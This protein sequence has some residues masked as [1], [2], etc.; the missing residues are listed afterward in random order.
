MI[1]DVPSLQVGRVNP[2]WKVAIV[3]SVWHRD[4]TDAL[5]SDARKALVEMGIKINN[6]LEIET[7]G[8]FEVPLFARYALLKKRVDGVIA[9]GVVL[10]G[11]TFH[12][13]LIAQETARGLMQLQLDTGKPVVFEVLYVRRIEDARARSIGKGAKGPLAAQ[14]LLSSLAKIAELR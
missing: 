1:G 5:V 4:C 6:I 12:A 9:L 3:R 11:E 13:R 2:K 10:E 14:T 7:P 8:S